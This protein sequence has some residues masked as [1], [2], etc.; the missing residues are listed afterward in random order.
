[1]V[2][3]QGRGEGHE[4]DLAPFSIRHLEI[5]IRHSLPFPSRPLLIQPQKVRKHQA[6]DARPLRR[7]S[8]F[9]YR[10]YGIERRIT[11]ISRKSGESIRVIRGPR[12]LPFSSRFSPRG[13]ACLSNRPF[14]F[15]DHPQRGRMSAGFDPGDRLLSH[16]RQFGQ[17]L[18]AK[19]DFPA[20]PYQPACD[21]RAGEL[22][23][24]A[25]ALRVHRRKIRQLAR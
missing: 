21:C 5:G 3:A 19:P 17:L 20:I 8:P 24:I 15:F 4:S 7:H 6:I 1:M 22:D 9:G 10:R 12:L 13:G 16:P 23:R 11:R 2:N 25:I 18:L 14:E